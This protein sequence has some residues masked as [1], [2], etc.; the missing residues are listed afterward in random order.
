MNSCDLSFLWL[1]EA[2]ALQCLP[3]AVNSVSTTGCQ[4]NLIHFALRGNAAAKSHC[5]RRICVWLSIVDGVG[6]FA[7]INGVMAEI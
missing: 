5:I 7:G 6:F 1:T 4:F 2:L 3:R